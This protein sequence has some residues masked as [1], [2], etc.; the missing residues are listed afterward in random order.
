MYNTSKSLIELFVSLALCYKCLTTIRIHWWEHA[1][2]LLCVQIRKIT[3]T[4]N[5][6]ARA[7]CLVR[8]FPLFFRARRQGWPQRGAWPRLGRPGWEVSKINQPKRGRQF[9]FEKRFGRGLPRGGP[10]ASV[11]SLASNPCAEHALKKKRTVDH[12]TA[13]DLLWIAQGNKKKRIR[14]YKGRRN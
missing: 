6:I 12:E 13:G 7:L 11:S 4:I 10:T 3:N 14:Q 8:R 9:V 2:R 5:P 1:Y